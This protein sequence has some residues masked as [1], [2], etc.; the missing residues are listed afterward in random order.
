MGDKIGSLETGKQ[1]D[2]LIMNATDYRQVAYQFGGNLIETV[3]K[4]G[5]IVSF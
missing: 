2:M 3:V 1:A 4:R 5:R